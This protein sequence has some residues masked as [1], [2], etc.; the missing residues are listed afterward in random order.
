[1]ICP[2]VLPTIVTVDALTPDVV[3][4]IAMQPLTGPD[5][6]SI[7]SGSIPRPGFPMSYSITARNNGPYV[8]GAFSA[9]FIYDPL[10]SFVQSSIPPDV[11]TPGYLEFSLTG[12]AAWEQQSVQLVFDVPADPLLIGTMISASSTVLPV[13]VD[14]D[15]AN[16]SYSITQMIVGAYDPNDKLARTSSAVSNDH[17]F[18]QQDDFID[19]TIRFQNTG[20]TEALH[21]HL[22]DTI[23][24]DLD[25]GTLQILATSHDHEVQ[26]LPGRVLRFDFP[27][28][29][30]PDSA[31]DELGSQGFAT[32]RLR[33]RI[34]IMVGDVLENFAD[35][36][37]DMNPPIR[38][39]TSQLVV[40][41][42]TSAETS[43]PRSH[44]RAW[45][46]PVVDHLN[47]RS[48]ATDLIKGWRI[49]DAFGR[50]VAQATGT[51][52]M[53]MVT[54]SCTG[55]STG[56]YTIE[57]ISRSGSSFSRVVKAE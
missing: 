26:L 51:A 15:P 41:T 35:I 11:S 23:S 37:F 29:M 34:D 36:H 6:M 56:A 27:E 53:E 21:V 47:I 40:E 49:Y 46:N 33:P 16:D 22:I 10:L 17:Y 20:N 25:L 13:A 28:I 52:P 44:V 8:H 31:S 55:M 39:N 57:I 14:A 32:F 30:L 54:I 4:N 12:M 7:C 43:E 9:T 18:I 24:T 19:Y 42:N 48:N 45:P 2:P 38:T 5:M 50:T 1:P 3:L